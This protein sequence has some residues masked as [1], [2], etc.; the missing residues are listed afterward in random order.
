MLVIITT[1][2]IQY[3]T[4]LWRALALDGRV[5][6]EVWFLTRH[7]LDESHDEGFGKTFA[8]DIDLL[9]GY[10]HR[11]LQTAA[12]AS[13][14]SFWRCRVTERL[15]DRLREVSAK[16]VW[17]QGW[18]V[19][20]YWQAVREAKAVGAQVWL[21]GESND[22]ARTPYWKRP[23]KRVVLGELFRRVDAALYI[24]SANRRF[25]EKFGI[26]VSRL[27][28]APYCVDN[29]RF[30]AQAAPLRGER[31]RLREHWGISEDA[32]CVLFCGKFVGKKRPMDVVQAAAALQRRG[33]GPRIHLL[34]VGSGELEGDLRE[35]CQVIGDPF[36]RHYP[37]APRPPATFAGFLNQ[38]EIS[39]AYVAAD[40][41]VLPSDSGE[42]WGLV[43]N[44]ALASG[45]TCVVSD[46]CGCA[47]DLVLPTNA[48]LRYPCGDLNALADA[49]C[50]VSA[51]PFLGSN[52]N[53][54][55]R[56]FTFDATINTVW[57]LAS[58]QA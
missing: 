19:A 33:K 14:A 13:P 17:I 44:E 45:L 12:G 55:I 27:H 51:K 42:T 53:E 30:K 23:L 22:L 6:F 57:T 36:V 15:R 48:K 20:A 37:G 38:T 18:Q 39:R 29:A 49:L 32:F 34:F 58:A 54:L 52:P 9:S 56:G 2:P 7:G 46:R 24:G 31:G 10:S 25:Y 41:L 3:Q 11:F 43:V 16:F 5:P 28:P 8:W 1:H 26:D 50:L 21:R 4:P 40:C 47:E 35:A